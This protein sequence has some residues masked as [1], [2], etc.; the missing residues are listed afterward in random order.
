MVALFGW[1]VIFGVTGGVTEAALRYTAYKLTGKKRG[2]IEDVRYNDGI[3]EVTVDIGDKKLNLA[4]VH[5][6]AN[7]RKLMEAI[8][9]GSKHFD[10]VEVMACPGGCVN[11]GGQVYVDYNKTPVEEVI[12]K[13]SEAI[14]KADGDCKFTGNF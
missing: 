3:K 6:L 11:G 14:Y 7:A 5:G 9:D 4:I 10:F 8:K 13:R 1:F 2:L 12:K